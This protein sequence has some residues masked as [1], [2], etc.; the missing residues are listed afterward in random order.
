MFG[1]IKCTLDKPTKSS[2]S[3]NFRQKRITSDKFVGTTFRSST[4]CWECRRRRRKCDETHPKCNACVK[5]NSHCVWRNEAPY[6]ALRDHKKSLKDRNSSVLLEKSDFGSLEESAASLALPTSDNLEGKAADPTSLDSME[7]GLRSNIEGLAEISA[8]QLAFLELSPD[9]DVLVSR[10]EQFELDLDFHIHLNPSMFVGLFL[11]ARGVSFVRHFKN[12][13]SNSLLVC[14]STSNYLCKTFILFAHMDE[15]IGHALASWGAYYVHRHYHSDVKHHLNQA[16]ALCAE[17]YPQGLVRESHDMLPLFCYHLIMLGFF[18]CAGDVCWWWK[19]FI[20]CHDLITRHGGLDKV[21]VDFC[22]SNDIKFLI[23]NFFYHDV[24]LSNAFVHGPLVSSAEYQ[25]VF[26]ADFYDSSYGIDP[27]QGC[28]NP[29][30]LVLCEELE[31]RAIMKAQRYSIDE[32]LNGNM[33]S[34]ELALREFNRM[35]A[36]HLA[37]CELE[38]ARIKCKISACVMDTTLPRDVS[39]RELHTKV[40]ATFVLVCKLYWILY[41]KQVLRRSIELQHLLVQLFDHIEELVDTQMVVILCL[42]LLTVGAASCTSHDRKR[43]EK[44]FGELIAK[45]P[46][47]NVRRAWVVVQETWRRDDCLDWAEV[48]EEWGWEMCV[49]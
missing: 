31:V 7:I 46:I 28:L 21:C 12:S 30:Y 22:R 45:C 33:D 8:S 26:S 43:T 11:D 36:Q 41:I 38:S 48:C 25:K 2:T 34:D 16:I 29:I 37:F 44:I 19:S 3:S 5:R 35:R 39:D 17:R 42:P 27:L 15:S 49:C 4:G 18:I 40:F 13:V 20:Q 14:P 6:A 32:M 9:L 24:L 1:V 47:E 10:T 23:S